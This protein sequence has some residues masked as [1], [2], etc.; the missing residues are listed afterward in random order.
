MSSEQMEALDFR[1]LLLEY[2]KKLGIKENELAVLLMLDHL[3]G[4]KNYLVTPDL[5]ATKMNLSAK[6]LDSLYVGLM[7]KGFITLETGK[8]TKI[9]LKPLRKKLYEA[10][11]DALVKE[12]SISRN[13]EKN[14]EFKRLKEVYEAQL[15][16][17]LLPI[18]ANMIGEW[19]AQDIP[20]EEIVEALRE[21][22]AKGKKTFPDFDKILFQWKAK[23][24]LE[25]NGV[26]GNNKDWDEDIEKAM[27]IAKTK[28]INDQ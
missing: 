10:F 1:Y 9:S 21:A 25:V 14:K 26:T 22:L 17:S 19:I 11:E 23:R 24:D 18:E 5:I 7:S 13:P 15:G 16:R 8:K 6:E 28:W 4:Q 2:Y 27:K 20:E 12:N 3:L